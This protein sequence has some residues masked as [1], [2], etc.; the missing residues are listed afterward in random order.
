LLGFLMRALLVSLALV[1]APAAAV[2]QINS[3]TRAYAPIVQA[4][5]GLMIE[6]LAPSD[7]GDWAYDWGPVSARVSR[8][9]HWHIFEPDPRDRPA[10]AV[11][12]RNGW[13]DGEGANVGVS[14]FG[15]DERVTMLT[16]E[17]RAFHTLYLLEALRAQGVDVRFVGDDESSSDY[18]LVAPGRREGRLTSTTVCTSPQSAAAQRCHNALTLRFEQP[19]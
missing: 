9:M 16:F 4:V 2:A 13:I 5:A 7:Y 14:V 1:L 3:E 8:H 19:A 10:D 12:R 18:M 11:V 6:A 15:T 17:V